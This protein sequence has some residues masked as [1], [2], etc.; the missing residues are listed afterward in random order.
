VRPPPD[1]AAVARLLL[2]AG[3]IDP[4]VSRVAAQKEP[5]TISDRLRLASLF[6]EITAGGRHAAADETLPGSP[7]QGT[8]SRR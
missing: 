6:R 7:G 1:T 3:I 8:G 5:A 4:V 2:A